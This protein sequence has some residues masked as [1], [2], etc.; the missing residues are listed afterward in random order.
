MKKPLVKCSTVRKP[1][2]KVQR[3]NN[4][5]RTCDCDLCDTVVKRRDILYHYFKVHDL[6]YEE[7]VKK[8]PQFKVS[9]SKL[10]RSCKSRN[11]RKVQSADQHMLH[12]DLCDTVL[13]KRYI[14]MHLYKLHGLSYQ[15]AVQKI[16][17][18]KERANKRRQGSS[19]LDPPAEEQTNKMMLICLHQLK[20]KS[21]IQRSNV[22][23]RN[24]KLS[25]IIHGI[26][27]CTSLI[28]AQ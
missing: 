1:N 14:L 21:W 19:K 26:S 6:P 8:V 2:Q 13:N 12:C 5:S 22:N 28:V 25:S 7:A 18:F 27:I 3:E 20:Q 4:S 10:V 9:L 17:G 15:E 24:A 11:S 16:S 23:A